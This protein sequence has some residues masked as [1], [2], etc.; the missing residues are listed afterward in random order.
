MAQGFW[1]RPRSEE[2]AYWWYAT[3]ES[4]KVSAKGTSQNRI[5]VSQNRSEVFCSV[6]NYLVLTMP[7]SDVPATTVVA[8]KRLLLLGPPNFTD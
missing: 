3:D 8:V 4:T 5:T 7:T 6:L 1:S 2:S